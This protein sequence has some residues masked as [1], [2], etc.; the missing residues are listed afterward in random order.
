MG[1]VEVARF[2]WDSLLFE[3]GGIHC[4][5]LNWWMMGFWLVL[6]F[7]ASWSGMVS[8]KDVFLRTWWFLMIESNTIATKRNGRMTEIT[9]VL[10]ATK[11]EYL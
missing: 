10:S 6:L 11:H 8:I 4:G 9:F 1:E 3:V 7:D 2:F 5:V